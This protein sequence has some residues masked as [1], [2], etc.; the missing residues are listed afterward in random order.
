MFLSLSNIT[1]LF[2]LH[3]KISS[4]ILKLLQGFRKWAVFP[5]LLTKSTIFLK[6]RCL[7]LAIIQK[8][9]VALFGPKRS[10]FCFKNL[11]IFMQKKKVVPWRKLFLNFKIIGRNN[12]Q[13]PKIFWKMNLNMNFFTGIFLHFLATPI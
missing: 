8:E 5:L 3:V 4:T 1:H 10:I 6:S 13:F 7:L 12:F 2:P 9:N 11:Q